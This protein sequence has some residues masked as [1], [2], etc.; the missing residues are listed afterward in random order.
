[1]IVK[2]RQWSSL[3]LGLGILCMITDSTFLSQS[4]LEG[5]CALM[6]LQPTAGSHLGGSGGM[7][8]GKILKIWVSEMRF[9]AFSEKI[10]KILKVQKCPHIY[11]YYRPYTWIFYGI[12]QGHNGRIYSVWKLHAW[13]REKVVSMR[14]GV[15]NTSNACVSRK[16]RES[17]KVCYS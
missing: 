2:S 12:L 15:R 3:I 6:D 11:R 5:H 1:M 10:Y 14:V 13:Q 8:P 4:F 9:S 16:M 17:W 7:P